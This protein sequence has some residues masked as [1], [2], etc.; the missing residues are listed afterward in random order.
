MLFFWNA[1]VE[2]SRDFAQ[3]FRFSYAVNV[4]LDTLEPD[5]DIYVF[6]RDR[7]V[8]VTPLSLDLTARL[9]IQAWFERFSA[10]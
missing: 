5:S 9:P 6:L 2:G 4:N 8:S 1:F 10:R 7:Q 3:K